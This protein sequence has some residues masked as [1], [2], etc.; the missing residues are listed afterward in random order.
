MPSSL[1]QYVR[2]K[3]FC[4]SCWRFCFL[5]TRRYSHPSVALTCAEAMLPLQPATVLM[6]VVPN[7]ADISGVLT[8]LLS[9]VDTSTDALGDDIDEDEEEDDADDDGPSR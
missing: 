2:Q 4:T 5:V 6:V 9:G 1:N 3:A 8:C 7:A